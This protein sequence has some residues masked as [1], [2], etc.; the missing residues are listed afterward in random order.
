MVRKEVITEWS[1]YWKDVG[2]SV[3]GTSPV[4]ENRAAHDFGDGK[5]CLG[6]IDP[7]VKG[8]VPELHPSINVCYFNNIAL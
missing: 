6:T 7:I 3:Y 8:C 1:V 5:R 4:C 2:A